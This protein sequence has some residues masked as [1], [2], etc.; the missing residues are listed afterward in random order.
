MLSGCRCPHPHMTHMVGRDPSHHPAP[1]RGGRHD[2]SCSI[3]QLW[4]QSSVVASP[5]LQVS[6]WEVGGPGTPEPG[7]GTRSL[8]DYQ[9]GAGF[10]LTS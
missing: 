4:T 7:E 9:V 6:S 8:W 2:R 1:G 5:S 10:L 3:C